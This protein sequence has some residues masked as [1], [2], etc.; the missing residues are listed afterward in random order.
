M[1]ACKQ[2]IVGAHAWWGA[3]EHTAR[4][5]VGLEK[6]GI[7]LDQVLEVRGRPQG[8]FDRNYAVL[9]LQIMELDGWTVCYFFE[10]N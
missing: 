5:G 2:Q 10:L 7:Q 6:L 9:V 3:H 4:C 8:R 1:M